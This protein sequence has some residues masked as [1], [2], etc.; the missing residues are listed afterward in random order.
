MIQPLCS[1]D[2]ELRSAGS[3]FRIT[4]AVY[5]ALNTT[6]YS[7]P[8]THD[9]GLK[10][11]V[12]D[13]TFKPPTAY[14]SSCLPEGNHL[15]MRRGVGERFTLV[16]PSSD[17][18]IIHNHHRTNWDIPGTQGLSRFMECFLHKQ[19]MVMVHENYTKK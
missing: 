6:K 8:Y 7:R 10:R 5:Q 18:D 1:K 15:R 12:Q 19:T 11:D 16:P 17:N 9:T 2:I 3:G 13:R 4:T 14:G